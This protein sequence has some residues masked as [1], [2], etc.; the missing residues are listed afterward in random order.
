MDAVIKLLH[1]LFVMCWE[2]KLIPDAWRK[3]IIH[4][5]P[6]TVNRCTDPLNYWGLTL[7]SCISK[8]MSTVL[9]NKISKFLENRNIIE[10]EQNG[11]RRNWSCLHHIHTLNSILQMRH[12]DKKNN[13]YLFCGLQ[14]GL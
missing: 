9:N 6:K 13:T 10:D 4:P 8:I 11:F 2:T 12:A 5:I 14:E 1:K 3:S 7:Q